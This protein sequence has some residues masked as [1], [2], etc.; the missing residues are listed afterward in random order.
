MVKVA[1]TTSLCANRIRV[2]CYTPQSC[3]VPTATQTTSWFRTKVRLIIKAIVGER[4]AQFKKLHTNKLLAGKL[5]LKRSFRPDKKR[6]NCQSAKQILSTCAAAENYFPWNCRESR[7]PLHEKLKSIVWRE[8]SSPGWMTMLLR[9]HK[10]MRAV[11]YNQD[12]GQM[13]A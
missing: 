1:K 8:S 3:P 4:G 2:M 6:R 11:M 13:V 7:R 5:G 9:P 12:S 10:G